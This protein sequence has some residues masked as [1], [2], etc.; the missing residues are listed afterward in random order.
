MTG[1]SLRRATV[2]DASGAV[3]GFLVVVDAEVEQL[4]VDRSWRR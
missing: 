2:A 3:A 1:V 4:S